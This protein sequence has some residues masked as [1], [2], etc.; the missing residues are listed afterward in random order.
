MSAGSASPLR[1]YDLPFE[2]RP[3]SVFG[4]AERLRALNPLTRVPTLVLD[5]GL[6]LTDSAAILDY[7]DGLVAAPLYP[8][9]EPGRHRAIRIATLACGAAEKAV[10]LFYERRLHAQTSAVWE[11]RCR[12]Q[13]GAVLA[14]L[15]AES[16]EAPFW[17]G[18]RIGHADIALACALRFIAEAHAGLIDLRPYPRLVARAAALEATAV[19]AEVRQ[20]FAAPA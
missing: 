14:T 8:R 17:G 7:L 4:D 3:W 11:D 20:P 5:D 10:S 12:T 19:F 13:I 15:E 16:P 18:D 9:A 1:L 2:H 6:V